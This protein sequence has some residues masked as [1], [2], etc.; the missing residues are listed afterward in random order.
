MNPNLNQIVSIINGYI[1]AKDSERVF[2]YIEFVKM[3]GYQNDTNTFITTY[4]DYVTRWADSKKSSI[5]I[6]DKDFIMSKM[7]D[8]LKSI[9]LDYSSYEEQ[10]FIAHINLTNKSHLKALSALFSRK[11]RQITQFYRKKRNESVTVVRR[12]TMKG[13]TKSIQQVIYEKVFD[14][15]FSNRN[16]MPSY[17]NIKRDLLISVENYVD[18][19]SEYF[20]I[21]RQKEFTDKT[22]AEMLSANMNDVDFRMYLEIELVVSE[23]LFSGNVYLQE[24]PLIAQVGVDLSQNCVGD[25]LA[26]KNNLMA[27]TQINQVDLN[28]QVALKRKLY[29]KF[30]GCDLWYLYVD[31][32]GNITMDVLC[33][34][35]NPTGNLLNCGTADTA[36]IENEQLTLL[37]HIG[38]FFKPDK[39]S[40]LKVNAK[41]YNWTVDLDVIQN[42]TMYV[43]PDP[44]KY[45]DIGNN[46]SSSYPLIM[47]YKLDYDIRNLSSGQA[48]SDPMVYLT[49]QG[50]YSYYSKQDDDF[51]NEKNSDYEYVFTWLANRGF[52]T[53]YQQDIWGNHFGILKGL[54]IIDE[55]DE[56][57]NPYKHII[58]E[59]GQVQTQISGEGDEISA[60]A[61]L[62]N[63]GYFE[64]PFFQGEVKEVVVMNPDTYN[65]LQYGQRDDSYHY[66]DRVD[67]IPC[68]ATVG[69]RIV[70]FPDKNDLHYPEYQRRFSSSEKSYGYLNGVRHEISMT[71]IGRAGAN[72][73][74]YYK[75]YKK[76]IKKWVYDGIES[77]TVP[78]DFD[79]ELKLTNTYR[80]TGLKINNDGFSHFNYNFIN[81]GSFERNIRFDNLTTYDDNFMKTNVLFDNKDA[82][83]NVIDDVILD[84]ASKDVF[85]DESIKVTKVKT[86]FDELHK[87]T[88]ELYIK[89]LNDYDGRPQLFKDVFNWVNWTK[90]G[91]IINFSI[92][93]DTVIV[94][95]TSHVLFIAYT[96]DGETI[97]NSLGVKEL[98]VLPKEDYEYTKLQ[99]VENQNKVYILQTKLVTTPNRNSFIIP[100]I[101]VFDILN[102]KIKDRINFY[103]LMYGQKFESEKIDKTKLFSDYIRLKKQY[104]NEDNLEKFYN[105]LDRTD[106]YYSKLR[107]FAI[108][109]YPQGNMIKEVAFTYNSALD[110][111]LFS[112]ILIDNNGTPYIHEYKFKC[113]TLQYFQGSLKSSLYT[114]K[115]IINENQEVI[116]VNYVYNSK[117]DGGITSMYPVV[118]QHSEKIFVTDTGKDM[119]YPDDTPT[120][121]PDVTLPDMEDWPELPDPVLPPLDDEIIPE[122]PEP[123]EPVTPPVQ[124]DEPVT[125]P[126]PPIPPTQDEEEEQEPEIPDEPDED[127]DV[128]VW[129]PSV[130]E[131]PEDIDP[132]VP[133]IKDDQE[134]DDEQGD[135][136]VDT[137]TVY[138]YQYVW[139][140]ELYKF[141]KWGSRKT[142][143]YRGEIE[144]TGHRKKNY[145]GQF[146]IYE[147]DRDIGN[148]L[149]Y[150]EGN[151]YREFEKTPI[152]FIPEIIYV[153]ESDKNG[154]S[155][156][157]DKGGINVGVIYL[158][159]EG[160]QIKLNISGNTVD[161][162]TLSGNSSTGNKLT[163]YSFSSKLVHK[164]TE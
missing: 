102:Y 13:S 77:N 18:T 52:I 54:Q 154:N 86:S 101:Y 114:I 117:I 33:R 37:S 126:T 12:N 69:Y 145:T 96:Y 120:P 81:Y 50:W 113:D 47:Q 133:D 109:Y 162:L 40:I 153:S 156:R 9:T 115:K 130:D 27:N 83:E 85:N 71:E 72:W 28:E 92:V 32:Q 44:T 149:Q 19:Y 38:L 68:E 157:N 122:Q 159:C 90:Y 5:S 7:I 1:N 163:Q 131:A 53:N 136:G 108:P 132:I 49:D 97:S 48:A 143:L 14:F 22:R 26:L 111:F 61:M 123:D 128:P 70:K 20:D 88:G 4:K 125:P 64:D 63:G 25:M 155:V 74:Q 137:S 119:V 42:D 98:F 75:P 139:N 17:K 59:E 91:E 82:F 105:F 43:F 36:T 57:G 118:E 95:T 31:L 161:T 10:D 39:T 58:L 35:K 127:I 144:L 3:F 67:A 116:D 80:W 121:E 66:M 8:I 94:E 160:Y 138:E 87:K 24:I 99:F 93:R 110:L 89:I 29:E 60:P 164:Y 100:T 23:I 151:T 55:V 73:R 124:P 158:M 79:K 104:V 150:R 135:D 62:L 129:T 142:V 15:V 107:D 46:K 6:S 78:F 65:A 56:D 41:D 147:I 146:R 141:I 34:A 16:I 134:E 84:F 103:D 21:P 152:K 51:K 30:L 2:T 148:P 112:F 11:I 45:G 76:K 140:I 106:D